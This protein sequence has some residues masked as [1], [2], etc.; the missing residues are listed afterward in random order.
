MLLLKDAKEGN[1][2]RIGLLDV[3][4]ATL[5]DVTA[6]STWQDP[7]ASRRGWTIEEEETQGNGGKTYMY[8]LFTGPT[9]ILGVRERRRNCKGFDGVPGTVERGNPGRIPNLSAGRDVEISSLDAELR[10]VLQPYGAAI[11]DL[12]AHV[13][14]A[15]KDRQAFTLV[16]GEQPVMLYK[17]RIDVDDLTAKLVRHEQ[18][19]L[20]LEQVDFYALHNGR[21]VNDGKKLAL[22]PITPYPG[23][24][25]P[26]VYEVPDQLPG[27]DG[28]MVSTTEGGTRERGRLVLHT[29]AENMQAAWRNLRPRWQIIYRTRHQMIGSKP[30]AEIAPT[31]PG[32]TFVYGTMELPALSQ[33]MSSTGAG[34]PNP[35]PW[36]RRSTSSLARRFGSSPRRSTP[37]A[38]RSSMNGRSTRCT[39]RIA[40]STSSRTGFCPTSGEGNGGPVG[41][42]RVPEA[43]VAGVWWSGA[44]SRTLLSTP[45]RKRVSMLEEEL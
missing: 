17:G 23:L 31:T 12:P 25:S 30:V 6:W 22:P 36:S 13:R 44:R 37:G 33:P 45:C 7:E 35:A 34:V 28:Q 14:R 3:G 16:E 19:T 21:P 20:C 2:A 18:A 39:L 38:R 10:Q 42:G 29:S 27:N 24:D 4:G 43:E 1:P 41:V 26:A 9:R 15:I 32:A 11:D 40:S 5:E 8:R